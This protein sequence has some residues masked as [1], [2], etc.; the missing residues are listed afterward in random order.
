MTASFSRDCWRSFRLSGY[1]G[2]QNRDVGPAWE[3]IFREVAA[4]GRDAIGETILRD[5]F[6]CDHCDFAAQIFSEPVPGGVVAAAHRCEPRTSEAFHAFDQEALDVTSVRV[7][8]AVLHDQ[9]E[10]GARGQDSLGV[11]RGDIRGAR[12]GI[13]RS[14][15]SGNFRKDIDLDCSK[16]RG[17]LAVAIS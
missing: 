2:H 8:L 14:R 9:A 3:V 11:E 13:D 17:R 10:R 15:A 4:L 12:D 1:I 7:V 16:Q 5:V 6:P